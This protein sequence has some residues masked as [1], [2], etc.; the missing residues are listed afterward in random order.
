MK[1]K[2][3][4]FN[5]LADKIAKELLGKILCRKINNKIFRAEII[6]TEACF[7]ESDPANWQMVIK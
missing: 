3:D 4:F 7:G 6:E 1:L 5:N 2:K